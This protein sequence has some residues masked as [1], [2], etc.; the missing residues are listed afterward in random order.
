MSIDTSGATS[1]GRRGL[2]R[3][4]PRECG[5]K[6][7][8]GQ[9]PR[10]YVSHMCGESSLVGGNVDGVKAGG[11]QFEGG[12]ETG[13]GWKAPWYDLW[14]GTCHLPDLCILSPCRNTLV[15]SA[16]LPSAPTGG[17]WP[18]AVWTGRRW[19]GTCPLASSPLCSRSVRG[20]GGG[21]SPTP[22]SHIQG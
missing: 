17:S 2:L 20:R 4:E 18:L 13:G 14:V 1:G 15:G 3:M 12:K 21:C 8:F 16:V 7:G 6:F 9:R 10:V 22:R 11:T 5:V 19:C